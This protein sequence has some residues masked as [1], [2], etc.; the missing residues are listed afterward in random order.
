M[1]VA[2]GRYGVSVDGSSVRSD[3]PGPPA[4]A[5][6]WLQYAPGDDPPPADLAAARL[7]I[8]GGGRCDGGREVRRVVV[9]DRAARRIEFAPDTSRGVGAGT[10]FFLEDALGFLDAPGEFFVDSTRGFLYLK[11]AGRGHPDRLGIARPVL[12]RLIQIRGRSRE[13]CVSN[14]VFE[15]LSLEETDNAP[16]Q[17]LWAYAG[18]T[19]GALIWMNNAERIEIRRCHLRNGGRSG[20]LIIGHNVGHVVEGCWIEHMGLNGISLCN[21]FSAP[22]GQAPTTDRCESHRIHNCRIHHIGELHTY[23]ECIT[24]FNV[25]HNDVGHCELSHSVR[26]AVTVRGNT[27]A[28]YGPP[29]TTPHPP[30]RGNRFH[31]L[32]ISRCG[33]DGGDMGALYCAGVNNPGDGNV[34]VFEQITVADTAAIPSVKD[35]PPDGIFLDW[36][37]MA[38]E[39][40]IRN[41]H[42]VRSQDCPF[43]SH[44]PEN[45]DTAVLDN[46]S[47]Q[48][49]FSEERMDYDRIGLTDEFPAEFGGPAPRPPPARAP[50]RLR[51]RAV[52]H[53]RVE[54]SWRPI[55][56]PVGATYRIE[57]DGRRLGYTTESRWIDRSV[58]ESSNFTYRVAARIGDFSHFGL[59]AECAVA[60]PNDRAPPSVTN[61]RTSADRRRVR[62]AFNDPVDPAMAVDPRC[63]RIEPPASIRSLELI[64]PSVVVLHVEGLPSNGAPCVA[65]AGVADRS[66]AANRL[67]SSSRVTAAPANVVVRYESTAGV[68]AGRLV[69]I[70]GGGGDAVLAGGA[71]IEE[72]LGPGGA[73]ALCLDG[74]T[75][76]AEGPDDLNL[77]PGDFTLALWVW[78]EGRGMVVSKGNGFGRP[79][80]WSFGLA[81]EGAPSSMALRVGNAWFATAERAVRDREWVHVAFVRKGTTGR[82]YVN[83]E[84]SSPPHDMTDIGPLVNDRPLRIGRRE[85]ERDPMFF[86]GRMAGLTIWRRA[87]SAAEVR[88]EARAEEAA[89]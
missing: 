41:V 71:A 65:V 4:P 76:Y 89:R 21:R 9:I 1:P 36:P 73:A 20:I 49:G 68:G 85:Y 88:R 77:G 26:Y 7:H 24:A 19:D 32:R 63:Y 60:T 2:L 84:P 64:A 29:V 27:G 38:V 55:A 53:N 58:G 25:S 22:G 40:V 50:A 54:L 35:I 82:I 83:G 52:A 56:K 13:A 28:Q 59:A 18:L 5:T 51:A 70:S 61:A 14:L 39:Q 43:R 45:G 47:W 10:R 66:A 81:K 17:P 86:K 8:F 72:G 69:D 80:Q 79:E 11:P 6:G 23:A 87:L 3:K 16:P 75:A 31:H 30:S 34:N 62:V 78:R 37:R 12:S 42:I 15:G 74:R 33:Q 67:E 46:V 57:R 48:P 44:G